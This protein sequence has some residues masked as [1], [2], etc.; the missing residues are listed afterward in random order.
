[1]A[2]ASNFCRGRSAIGASTT[3]G[4]PILPNLSGEYWWRYPEHHPESDIAIKK[5]SSGWLADE[6]LDA[7]LT[8]GLPPNFH[9]PETRA[10]RRH[11]LVPIAGSTNRGQRR[12]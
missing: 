6:T 5:T 12:Q 2:E 10:L 4:V 9:E 1:M 3:I 7:G 8:Q 11:Q